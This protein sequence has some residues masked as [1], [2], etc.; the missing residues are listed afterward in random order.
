MQ[1]PRGPAL[2]AGPQA[3][4]LNLQDEA[5]ELYI[6]AGRRLLIL[7]IQI[8]QPGRGGLLQSTTS[9]TVTLADT[10]NRRVSGLE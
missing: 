1:P 9:H 10:D 3:R 5:V 8:W 2:K 4:L 6:F 7:H